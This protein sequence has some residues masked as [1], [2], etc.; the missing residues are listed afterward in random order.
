MQRRD[1][2]KDQIEQL[3]RVLSK[4]LSDFIGAKS[5]GNVAQ[6][7]EISNERLQSELD[8][9]IKKLISLNNID[10]KT[11]LNTRKLTEPH[12]EILS[13]YLVENG[14]TKTDK[15]EME[16][17]LKKAIILLNIADEISKTMS[18]ERTQLKNE[19]TSML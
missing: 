6:G 2:L 13:K 9:N 7:I 1:L 5:K 8:I 15:D 18:F 19:I 17:Y 12:L 11:Y 3:G 10:L 14:K 16:L 4:I